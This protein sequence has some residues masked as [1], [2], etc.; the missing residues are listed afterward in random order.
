MKITDPISSK[1]LRKKVRHIKSGCIG[2]IDKIT[3]SIEDEHNDTR[4]LRFKWLKKPSSQFIRPF[5]RDELEFYTEEQ[6][7]REQH[8]D[9]YL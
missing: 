8:A 7:Q 3:F 2:V 6:E 9:K 1:W 4:T 5:P